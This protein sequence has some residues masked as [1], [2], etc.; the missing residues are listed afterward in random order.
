MLDVL[1][2]F[3]IVTRAM[4]SDKC[5]ATNFYANIRNIKM[6]AGQSNN[7]FGDLF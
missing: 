6:M 5:L 1:L 4:T 2:L 3:E 7:N